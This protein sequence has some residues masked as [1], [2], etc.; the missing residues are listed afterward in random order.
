LSKNLVTRWEENSIARIAS[1]KIFQLTQ[2]GGRLFQEYSPFGLLE[3]NM[4][5]CRGFV[6][7]GKPVKNSEFENV[8]FSYSNFKSTWIEK[9]IFKKCTFEAVDFSE[10]ADHGNQFK[11][12]TFLSCR[13]NKAA[14]GYSGSK[15]SNLVFDNCNFTMTVFIR[16]EFSNSKFN[17]CRLK[18]I[19]FNASSFE[20]CVFK[21]VLEDVWFRGEFPLSSDVKEFGKPKKN[22]M[23]NVSFESADLIDVTFSDNCNLSSVKIKNDGN[24]L[25]YDNWK[26]RLTW[27][28][29]KVASWENSKRKEAEIFITSSLVHAEKQDWEIVNLDS[30]KKQCGPEVSTKI[31]TELNSI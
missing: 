2:K 11:D 5:D 20:D 22:E 1:Q 6:T 14:I 13:F 28:K 16:A 9:S 31:I 18:G 3:T 27:L 8:D 19:D 7:H 4:I 15:F 23:R 12:C 17:Q 24:Y 10:I 26:K 30:L 29:S 21:G 25:K